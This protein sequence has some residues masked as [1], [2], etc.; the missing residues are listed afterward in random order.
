M[1]LF[2]GSSKAKLPPLVE[3]PTGNMPITLD[4]E[5]NIA[6]TKA[7]LQQE[8]ALG[9]QDITLKPDDKECLHRIWTGLALVGVG[10]K[11]VLAGDILGSAQSCAKAIGFSR[12]DDGRQRNI[13]LI[14]LGRVAVHFD[15]QAIADNV[16]HV[17]NDVANKA[18][19]NLRQA[20]YGSGGSS[21]WFGKDAMQLT[22]KVF[23][24]ED[25]AD[26]A[27]SDDPLE[28][29]YAWDCLYSISPSQ[30][31]EY[32]IMSSNFRDGLLFNLH[33]M[34]NLEKQTFEHCKEKYGIDLSKFMRRSDSRSLDYFPRTIWKKD[35]VVKT[36]IRSLLEAE[37]FPPVP[38]PEI[39]LPRRY[40]QYAKAIKENVR[41][42]DGIETF[43]AYT[44]I[45]NDVYAQVQMAQELKKYDV[46]GLDFLHA[47]SAEE[48]MEYENILN[49]EKSYRAW[50]VIEAYAWLKLA[51]VYAIAEDAPRATGCL[52]TAQSVAHVDPRTSDTQA[53]SKE[54][55]VLSR[56]ELSVSQVKELISHIG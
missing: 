27:A 55:G 53:R 6:I 52:K 41:F 15:A 39:F 22:G 19:F 47:E 3:I 10:S 11:R 43:A 38:K 20:E 28:H 45:A 24:P 34:V 26:I 17:L 12:L 5:E 9:L 1:R 30:W 51:E 4:E 16:R 14:Y 7:T 46:H 56:W 49:D 25:Y 54:L 23:R 13:G 48:L 8:E 21:T 44:Q 33:L 32:Y 42:D 2:G 40:D 31:N 29:M 36:E 50:K 18:S 37:S 35:G